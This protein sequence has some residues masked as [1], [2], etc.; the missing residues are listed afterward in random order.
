M[1]DRVQ[2]TW[3]MPPSLRQKVCVK[4]P[5]VT[6]SSIVRGVFLQSVAQKVSLGGFSNEEILE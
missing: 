3:A 6:E 5:D 2:D 4:L 1:S